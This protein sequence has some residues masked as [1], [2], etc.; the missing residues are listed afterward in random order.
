VV[1]T[2]ACKYFKHT[3]GNYPKVI[4]FYW[5]LLGS[6]PKQLFSVASSSQ[7][8]SVKARAIVS[9][10]GAEE[11]GGEWLCSKDGKGPTLC[12]HLRLAE[13]YLM[14][15]IGHSDKEDSA[16]AVTSDVGGK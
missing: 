12:T 11:S 1:C 2:S 6:P 16:V 4:L 3:L 14:K 8:G 7:Q 15:L 13:A 9:H 5:D 10:I